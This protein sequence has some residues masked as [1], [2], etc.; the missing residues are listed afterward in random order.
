MLQVNAVARNIISSL[1]NPVYYGLA[2]QA[3]EGSMLEGS[4][5]LDDNPGVSVARVL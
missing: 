3:D 1:E 5:F 2:A 4:Q